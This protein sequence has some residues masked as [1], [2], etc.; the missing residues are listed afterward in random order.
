MSKQTIILTGLAGNFG[1]QVARALHR[2]YRV[3]GLDPRRATRLPKDIE[4]LQV[5]YRRRKAENVFRKQRPYALIH[6]GMIHRMDSSPQE[7]L[8]FNVVGTQRLVEYCEQY[9]V[10]KMIMLSSADV[11]GPIPGSSHYINED[12]TLQGDLHY[13][14]MRALVSMDRMVQTFC[15]MEPKIET[16]LLRPVHILGPRLCNASSSYLRLP[17]IP[18]IMGYDPML[19]VIHKNDLLAL[20]EHCLEPRLR[21][22]FNVASTEA[23]PLSRLLRELGKRTIPLPRFLVRAAV[24][25]LW[26][27]ELLAFPPPEVDHLQYNCVVDLTR[28][29]EVMKFQPRYD[30]QKIIKEMRS[31]LV[32]GQ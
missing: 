2:S 3:V 11:Y 5:D 12:A 20:I 9:G 1:R 30:W 21:G 27:Y 32:R 7:A 15:Y 16:V 4:H 29:R 17:M 25:R 31:H 18:V 13:P 14:E 6:L 19:H 26:R 8:S 10:K 22:V 24:E 23:A 28:M